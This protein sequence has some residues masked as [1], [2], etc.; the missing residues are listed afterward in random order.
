[1]GILE[2]QAIPDGF[3][4][5]EPQMNQVMVA[6]THQPI[7]DKES[8]SSALKSIVYP[9][10]FLDYE[11]FAPAIPLFDG[12]KPYQQVCF[13][14]SLHVLPKEGAELEHYEFLASGKENPV[15]ALAKQLKQDIATNDGTVIVWNK[16]F[17][18]SRNT[19]MGEMYP[20]YK[21]FMASVNTRVFD[22]MEIFAKQYYVHPRFE[23]S[24][25]IKKVLPVLVPALTYKNLG[26]QEGG[27]ASRSWFEM[28]FGEME[29]EK[30]DQI[31]NNLLK[32]CGL[33]SLAMFRIFEKLTKL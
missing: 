28:N 23:G 14:Y 30:R 1:M 33:D 21:E 7:I 25:S 5:T 10:Y 13:Q 29:D 17:E 3:S 2:I 16:S 24:Y 22:L 32:Y 15:P 20:E 12:T 6:K 11:T 18:M 9:I 19:E 31:Y 8:I 27:T 26:I 4:L